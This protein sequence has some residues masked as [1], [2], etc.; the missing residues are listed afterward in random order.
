VNKKHQDGKRNMSNITV[1]ALVLP[2]PFLFP[3]FSYKDNKLTSIYFGP[4]RLFSNFSL[5]TPPNSFSP[6]GFQFLPLNQ[7]KQKFEI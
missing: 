6:L 1:S 7:G 3:P 4:S 5:S 2:I